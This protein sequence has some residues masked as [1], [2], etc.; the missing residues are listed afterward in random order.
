MKEDS[1]CIVKTAEWTIENQ[2]NPKIRRSNTGNEYNEQY[3]WE[4][5]DYNYWNK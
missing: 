5:I 1:T 2:Y 3:A 4:I